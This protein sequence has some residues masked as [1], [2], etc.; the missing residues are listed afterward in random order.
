LLTAQQHPSALPLTQRGKDVVKK[1]Q[2]GT[3]EAAA[4]LVAVLF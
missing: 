4:E 1:V 3:A 2:S